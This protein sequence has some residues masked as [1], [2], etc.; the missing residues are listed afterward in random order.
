MSPIST[1]LFVFS[2][3]KFAGR[4]DLFLDL[5]LPATLGR[6]TRHNYALLSKLFAVEVLRTSS[7]PLLLPRLQYAVPQR[8]A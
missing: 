1:L 5:F 6:F 3:I 2:L 7:Q 8:A 4:S